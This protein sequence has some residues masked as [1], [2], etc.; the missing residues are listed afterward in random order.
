MKNPHQAASG[1]PARTGRSVRPG[2]PEA[3]EL[4]A[5]RAVNRI[6]AYARNGDAGGMHRA[7]QR[8]IA[9]LWTEATRPL[10][11]SEIPAAREYLTALAWGLLALDGHPLDRLTRH[12]LKLRA[13][14]GD[15]PVARLLHDLPALAR[16]VETCGELR[17]SL[18]ADL[19]KRLA[20]IGRS[21]KRLDHEA[22]AHAIFAAV[23]REVM[24]DPTLPVQNRCSDDDALCRV[25]PRFNLSPR[26]VERI[27]YR[28]EKLYRLRSHA[29]LTAHQIHQA[30]ERLA[31][32]IASRQ[33]L[34]S[35]TAPPADRAALRA[36]AATALLADLRSKQ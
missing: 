18:P 21:V 24:A 27:Y 9:P 28:Q 30:S 16:L 15:A 11:R 22:R 14:L 6:R 1:L 12:H 3:L 31:K 33:P 10:G 13:T 23:R 5:E 4:Q 32:V 29:L 25:A 8:W 35:E 2:S 26:S 34:P 19:K 7:L 36:A 17:L 20:D